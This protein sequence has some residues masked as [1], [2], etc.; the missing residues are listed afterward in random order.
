[1]VTYTVLTENL[2]T[3]GTE[4]EEGLD[5]TSYTHSLTEEEAALCHTYQFTVSS[6]N[7][8]GLSENSTT[9]VGVHPSGQ[10]SNEFSDGLVDVNIKSAC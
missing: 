8:V 10:Y 3:S 6:Q 7:A 9:A 1:V 2:N 5:T 4:M